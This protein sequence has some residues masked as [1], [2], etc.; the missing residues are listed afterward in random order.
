MKC[1]QHC[2]DVSKA[3]VN[4][5]YV[6][7]QHT[8]ICVCVKSRHSVLSITPLDM[9]KPFIS[10]WLLLNAAA[11]TTYLQDHQ[12]ITVNLN[13][14]LFCLGLSFPFCKLHQAHIVPVVKWH[15]TF[16]HLCLLS[17]CIIL[18]LAICNME[19]CLETSCLKHWS[20]I[21]PLLCL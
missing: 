14:L 11:T 13:S 12:R 21:C 3:L 8:L 6:Y 7:R 10:N 1:A 15:D 19:R 17:A 20:L 18:F 2:P 16:P 9:T 4:A 5:H